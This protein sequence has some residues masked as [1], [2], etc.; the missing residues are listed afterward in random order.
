LRREWR[1]HYRGQK[2]IWFL[3]RL[4]GRDCDVRL[5]ASS[6][7]EFDAWRWSEYWMPMDV[8]IEFKREV[9]QRALE[10]LAPYLSR[11]PRGG[12]RG[13]RGQRPETADAPEPG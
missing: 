2:Q 9:Y 3:L 11:R 10:E 6:K 12:A 8:V 1:G 4:V 7:P 13:R 5:R